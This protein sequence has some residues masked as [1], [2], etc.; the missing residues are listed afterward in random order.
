MKIPCRY[1]M[2]MPL[3]AISLMI[4]PAASYAQGA[5]VETRGPAENTAD[6]T[7]DIIAQTASD[8]QFAKMA[9]DA[10]KYEE[11]IAASNALL[12]KDLPAKERA[13]TWLLLGSVYYE[14]DDYARAI[15]AFQNAVD[16]GGLNVDEARSLSLNIAQLYI[17]SGK[18]RDGAERLEAY[19]TADHPIKP[20]YIDML[21]VAWMQAE[22]Y[23]RALPWLEKWYAG[24]QPKERKHF[25]LMTFVYHNLGMVEAQADILETMVQRFPS[26]RGLRKRWAL[27]LSKAGRH[28]DA[29][30][31][32]K[33]LYLSG[34]ITDEADVLDLVEAYGR[35]DMPYQAAQLLEREMNSGAVSQTPQTLMQLSDYWVLARDYDK[36]AAVFDGQDTEFTSAQMHAKY[37][38]V[39]YQTGQCDRAEQSLTKA[40]S[41]G[42]DK[43][44]AWMWIGLCRYEAAQNADRIDCDMT[45]LQKENAPASRLRQMAL[46]GL[47]NV[48]QYSATRASADVWIKLIENEVAADIRRC[49]YFE[50]G[51]V[52]RDICFGDIHRA[53][54]AQPIKGGKFVLD[55]PDVCEAHIEDYNSIYRAKIPG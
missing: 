29:F 40:M 30:A 36:A 15:S 28:E 34:E 42:F 37:G 4:L 32:K 11:S 18:Y 38:E 52:E 21:I 49:E 27:M 22:E 17:A 1:F 45:Q 48:P 10:G 35:R 12:N 20:E 3:C 46:A 7:L 6:A 50:C 13:Q 23:E 54:A 14:L 2:A 44:K 51:H 55:N 31:V 9:H 16:S 41:M 47:K 39:L 24:P 26:E 33:M 53:Y 19:I 8:F 25:D 43:G 5:A